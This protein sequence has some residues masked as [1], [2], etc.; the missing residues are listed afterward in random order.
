MLVDLTRVF[1]T[2][3]KQKFDYFAAVI[4]KEVGLTQKAEREEYERIFEMLSRRIEALEKPKTKG[5]KHA[6]DLFRGGE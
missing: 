6:G 3:L 2:F 4:A 1:D 5:N